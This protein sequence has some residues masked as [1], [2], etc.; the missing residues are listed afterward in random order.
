MSV[1]EYKNLLLLTVNN[2]IGDKRFHF[3]TEKLLGLFD[4]KC[5]EFTDLDNK[6]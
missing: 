2:S 4:K 3:T 5:S 1:N 6:L